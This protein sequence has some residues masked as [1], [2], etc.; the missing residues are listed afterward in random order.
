MIPQSL[1]QRIV[2]KIINNPMMIFGPNGKKIDELTADDI[3]QA[4]T[5]HGPDPDANS[6]LRLPEMY[7]G[8]EVAQAITM[9]KNEKYLEAAGV[10]FDEVLKNWDNGGRNNLTYE[11]FDQI[12]QNNDLF[13]QFEPFSLDR[14]VAIEKTLEKLSSILLPESEDINLKI[15]LKNGKTVLDY[16]EAVNQIEAGHEISQNVLPGGHIFKA[17]L[18]EEGT[19]FNVL[20]AEEASGNRMILIETKG[21]FEGTKKISLPFSNHIG[22]IGFMNIDIS[23]S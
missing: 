9:I 15:T 23:Y 18:S 2:Q 14:K 6:L 4:L 20:M 13:K 19:A 5:K 8:E 21:M 11:A 16:P 1:T 17:A 7:K 10:L 12:I 22:E 3:A